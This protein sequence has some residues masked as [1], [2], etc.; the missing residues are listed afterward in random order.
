MRQPN[1][2][3]TVTPVVEPGL[4]SDMDSQWKLAKQW[5]IGRR[6]N[7]AVLVPHTMTYQAMTNWMSQTYRFRFDEALQR[8]SQNAKAM[9]NDGFIQGLYRNRMQPVVRGAWRIIARGGAAKNP[10]VKKKIEDFYRKI[11]EQTPQWH[12]FRRN[13][14]QCVWYGRF[15]VQLAFDSMTYQG[16]PFMWEG[17]PA[18]GISHWLPVLG[19]KITFTFDFDPCIRVSP[20]LS[21][22]WARRD[23]AQVLQP[24]DPRIL[25]E[26]AGYRWTEE[27]PVI[28]LNNPQLLKQFLI[29]I[30]EIQDAAWDDPQLAGGVRGVGLRNYSFWN[31]DNRQEIVSWAML[32]LEEFG[33]NGYTVVGYDGPEGLRRQQETFNN[34]QDRILFVP[35]IP[36]AEERVTDMVTRLEPAG[37]GNDAIFKWANDYFNAHLIIL[38]LGHPLNMQTGP[39]GMGSNMGDKAAQKLRE[40]NMGDAEI[41]DVA[42]TQDVLTQ[43][44]DYNDPTGDYQLEFESNVRAVDKAAGLEAAKKFYDMGGKVPTSHALMLA[45]IPELQD[46]EDY[47]QNPQHAQAEQQLAMQGAAPP[48]GTDDTSYMERGEQYQSDVAEMMGGVPSQAQ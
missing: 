45:E 30:F 26:H 10:I 24:N 1:N 19:D 17:K 28:V 34:P 5:S 43:L 3:G 7:Q 35:I 15:G 32:H 22:T 23:G 42:M 40:I 16:R 41:L 14:L 13:V 36:G 39:T 21:S 20:M 33:A 44:K 48:V 11:L 2:T 8:N 47:L 37:Q 38:F 46:G 9:L 27:G 18:V 4:S 31:W 12:D 6:G 29:T 25:R